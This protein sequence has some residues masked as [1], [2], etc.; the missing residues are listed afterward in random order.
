M[1]KY[2]HDLRDNYGEINSISLATIY[3]FMTVC[4]I[5]FLAITFKMF[6]NRNNDE[7]YD[8]VYYFIIGR[9][10]NIFEDVLRKEVKKEYDLQ[11]QGMQ[12]EIN[13]IE[14]YRD[15]SDNRYRREI[16]AAEQSISIVEKNNEELLD[17]LD[18]INDQVLD[19]QDYIQVKNKLNQSNIEKIKDML[20][21]RLKTFIVGMFHSMKVLNYQINNAYV[22]PMLA[23]MISPLKGLYENVKKSLTD[24]EKLI[25]STLPFDYNNSMLSD[26]ESKFDKSDGPA[27]LSANFDNSNDFFMGYK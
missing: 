27:D 2:I 16:Q 6:Y 20:K 18:L 3:I 24:N 12:D 14:K 4:L 8:S 15:E 10:R 23:N 19:A 13:D 26:F 21:E 25:Q 1:P 17:E 22:T 5:I 9:S 11:F 7:Y